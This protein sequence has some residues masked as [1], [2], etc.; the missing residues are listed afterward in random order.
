VL[1]TGTTG[2]FIRA[3]RITALHGEV[4]VL[5]R[6]SGDPVLVRRGQVLAACFHP[7]LTIGHPVTAMF[8]QMIRARPAAID[9]VGATQ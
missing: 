4:E 2:T 3:P 9:S 1:P 6:R 7:E 8:A 5:A